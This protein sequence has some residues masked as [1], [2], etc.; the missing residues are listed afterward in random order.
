MLPSEYVRTHRGRL[1][2]ILQDLVRTPSENKPPLGT[3]TFCQQYVSDHL[4]RCGM[5]VD[6]YRPDEVPGVTS[7]EWY[8][9]GRD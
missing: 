7:H 8:W 3:E 1:H 6:T 5:Q 4:T 9:P 2:T